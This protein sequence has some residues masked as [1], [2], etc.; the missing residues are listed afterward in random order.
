[1]ARGLKWVPGEPARAGS[2]EAGVLGG[3]SPDDYG[4]GGYGNGGYGVDRYGTLQ[5][6]GADSVNPDTGDAAG[7]PL[8]AGRT[9]RILRALSGSVAVG[10]VMLAIGIVV[11]SIMGGRR[12]FPGPGTESLVVHLAGSAAVV[13]LQ[14]ISDRRRGVLAAMAS[15]AVFAVA[16]A[17]LW[18][19]WWG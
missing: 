18:T 16:A 17:V 14:R 8:Y 12:G 15:L 5:E 6:Q 19:Q 7:N 4:P 11:V 13:L 10:L 2:D 3:E 9:V 1:M